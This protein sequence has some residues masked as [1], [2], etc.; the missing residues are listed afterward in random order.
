MRLEE[1]TGP[2]ARG[3]DQGATRRVLRNQDLAMLPVLRALLLERNVTRAG[4]MV[5]LS[6]PAAS[7]ALARLRRRFRDELLVRVGREFELT[8]FASTLL[9]RLETATA[10][11]ERL[12]GEEF[13]PTTT[14][15]D[16]TVVA[17]DYTVAIMAEEVNKILAVESPG[18]PTIDLRQLTAEGAVDIDA[19]IRHHDAVVLPSE[20]V[21]GYPGVPLLRDRWVCIV[22]R[23]NDLV[24]DVLTRDHLETLPLVST[25][26]QRDPLHYAPLRE[27]RKLGIEPRVDAVTDSFLTV[28][29]LVANSSR[30]AFLH[31]RL[32]RRLAPIVPIRILPSPVDVGAVTLSMRWHP[33]LDDDPAHRWFRHLLTDA[34]ERIMRQEP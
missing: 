7:A 23:S 25:Y 17:S 28:P 16:F 24:A 22:A 26:S 19:L 15:R 4:E 33:T 3:Q 11:L 18:S 21:R 29:F 32:A 20:A 6:Q 14:T 5:G 8:P 13:D 2:A 12:F 1:T 34:A 10:A 9:E 30:I 31:E 27:M